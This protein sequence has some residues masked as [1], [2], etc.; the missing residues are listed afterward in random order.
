MHCPL[1]NF[2]YTRIWWSLNRFKGRISNIN[3]VLHNA[4]L[5][6]I[7]AL[8]DRTAAIQTLYLAQRKCIYKI[9]F[10]FYLLSP[11][12]HDHL[13]YHWKHWILFTQCIVAYLL[14]ARTV[15]GGRGRA[16]GW[17]TVLQAGRPR[18]R[19][20]RR[21]FYFANHAGRHG[22]LHGLSSLARTLGS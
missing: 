8:P 2:G 11:L 14:K 5:I 21:P 3:P 6:N 4:T 16:V 19:F 15:E 9:P 10:L 20:P 18:V 12:K 22:L 7:T 17:S 13:F 1:Y